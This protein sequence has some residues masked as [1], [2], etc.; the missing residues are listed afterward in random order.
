MKFLFD[1][2]GTNMRVG[3]SEDGEKIKDYRTRKTPESLEAGISELK[4]MFGGIAGEQ[5][6]ILV[7]GIAGVIDGGR[8]VYSPNLTGWTGK[9]L[10]KMLEEVF[11]ARVVLENDAAVAALGEANFG[12]SRDRKISAYVT[13]GT[14]VGGAR[15]VDGKIDRKV[16]GFEPGQQIVDFESYSTLEDFIS[17]AAIEREYGESPS[18]IQDEKFWEEATRILAVGLHNLIVLWS[19]EIIVVGG[20]V[21][22][23]KPGIDVEKIKTHLNKISRAFPD[24]PEVKKA[25]LGDLSGLYGALCLETSVE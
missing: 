4:A 16:Y 11:G 15:I 23:D 8:L 19:P 24:L 2:G 5:S 10:K 7:G 12:A 22:L 3:V 25:E 13:V 14:G 6:E 20:S 17:G 1:I 9:P 18:N 21:A